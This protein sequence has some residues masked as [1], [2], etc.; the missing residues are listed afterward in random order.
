[1]NKSNGNNLRGLISS[2]SY[3]LYDSF[4]VG[5][6]FLSV[7]SIS[8]HAQETQTSPDWICRRLTV[9]LRSRDKNNHP[10][11]SSDFVRDKS[12]KLTCDLGRRFVAAPKLIGPAAVPC[13]VGP[14][15]KGL[16]RWA[17]IYPRIHTISCCLLFNACNGDHRARLCLCQL[18]P[19][20]CPKPA[21]H[22]EWHLVALQDFWGES[23]MLLS[24]QVRR[25]WGLTEG[26]QRIWQQR[27]VSRTAG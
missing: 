7:W 20:I 14:A 26:L 22:R 13:Q 25:I 4:P 17:D 6:D 3:Y 19:L 24:S 21:C 9:E 15:L 11:R 18:F 27:S 10:S 8:R 23:E 5:T 2:D 16:A 1:M 12:L